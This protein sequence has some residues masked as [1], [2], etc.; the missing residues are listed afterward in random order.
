MHAY[1]Q[2]R[3][4]EGEEQ[5]KHS[6]IFMHLF[7][8]FDDCLCTVRY[9]IDGGECM[10]LYDNVLFLYLYVAMECAFVSRTLVVIVRIDSR[11]VRYVV[12]LMS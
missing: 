2:S 6:A 3:C 11:V 1:M 9:G 5:G 10:M 4:C 12:C 7:N 8:C